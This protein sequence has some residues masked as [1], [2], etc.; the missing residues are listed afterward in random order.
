M[1]HSESHYKKLAKLVE[2]LKRHNS[3]FYNFE[4]KDIQKMYEEMPVI[5][6]RDI[7]LHFEEY[8]SDLFV[9]DY[10]GQNSILEYLLEVKELSA[11]HDR[12]YVGK[13][14]RKWIIETTTGSTGKPFTI[15]K[16]P[17]EK[18]IESKFLFDMRKRF[19][20]DVNLENG[21]L[22]L[23]PTDNYIKSISYRGISDKKIPLILNYMFK[24]MPKWLLITTL[25]LRKLYKSIIKSNL[26]KKVRE[27]RLFFI[28]ITS[29]TLSLEEKVE[30]EELFG[31]PIVN[32]FGCRE[33]WNIA[34]ECPCGKMHVNNKYLMVDLMDE[35]GKLIKE[36]GKE[37]TVILTSLL[38]QSFPFIKYH[39]ADYAFFSDEDCVCGN[40]APIIVFSGGR[41]KDKLIGSNYYGTEIFRK[42]MRYIY[43]KCPELEVK[44][45]FI[46]QT[47]E[48]KIR[49]LVVLNEQKR[50]AFE[51]IFKDTLD[52]LIG[53]N[54][55]VLL[56]TYTDVIMCNKNVLKPE[57]FENFY[58]YTEKK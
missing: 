44:D 32:Q 12:V 31:C 6:K 23:Q 13:S 48:K 56:F 25:L 46:T 53:K 14:G 52:F 18:L 1:L 7:L 11:N 43:F 57:I 20:P 42:L 2:N 3:Y 21:F 35:E 54:Y 55:Y 26:E 29:Q 10:L 58:T 4:T 27:L 22:L 17:S 28:E 16:S 36:K 40:S 15:V 34:Y 39:L 51:K 30:L 41:K 38:H 49:I 47:E 9:K 24:C 8:I 45:I 5:T 33:V 50:K 37:G 19:Y